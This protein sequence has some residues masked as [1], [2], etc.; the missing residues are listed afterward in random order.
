MGCFH[1][2][3]RLADLVGIKSWTPGVFMRRQSL[4]FAIL[5]LQASLLRW[6]MDFS[7]RSEE[8]DAA[9]ELEEIARLRGG[10]LPAGYR[11]MLTA[12]TLAA[13]TRAIM[14]GLRSIDSA[15]LHQVETAVSSALQDTDVEPPAEHPSP[16]NPLEALAFLGTRH[17]YRVTPADVDRVRQEYGWSDAELTDLFY[18]IAVRNIVERLD[19]LLARQPR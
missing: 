13:S 6:G 15:M 16:R 1:F 19:R 12:P 7:P 10:Q 2:I 8:V 17:A 11:T 9:T 18:A 4:R 5:R 3:T 14:S